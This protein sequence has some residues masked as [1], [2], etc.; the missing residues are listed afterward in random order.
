M[1]PNI[2]EMV[3]YE[4]VLNTVTRQEAPTIIDVRSVANKQYFTMFSLPQGYYQISMQPDS[5][6]MTVVINSNCRYRYF[7]VPFELIGSPL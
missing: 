6:E 1:V 7:R 2:K 4:P 3:T 5:M